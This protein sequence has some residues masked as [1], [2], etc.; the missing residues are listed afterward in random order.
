MRT[1]NFRVYAMAVVLAMAFALMTGLLLA[2]T[3][4]VQAQEPDERPGRRGIYGTVVTI[5]QENGT[6]VIS[7]R[8]GSEVNVDIS[9]TG[10]ELSVD[11]RVALLVQRGE[12]GTTLDVIRGLVRPDRPRF[13]HLTGAVVTK[14]DG[15]L[16]I[17]DATGREHVVELSE[18]VTIQAN[19][20][21]LA[22]VIASRGTDRDDDGRPLVAHASVSA[23]AITDRVR[24]HVEVI[25]GRAQ[26]GEFHGASA[27]T[28]IQFLTGLLDTMSIRIKTVYTNVLARVGSLRAKDAV[29]S[30]MDRA[31]QRL[32]HAKTRIAQRVV[33]SQDGHPDQGTPGILS[34]PGGRPSGQPE[35]TPG[36]Q[37]QG[38]SQ[39][40]PVGRPDAAG[41]PEDAPGNRG[42]AGSQTG[43]APG[44][45]PDDAGQP[46]NTPRGSG[47]R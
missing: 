41:Q 34:N 30:A 8:S 42:Q 28:R 2:T 37:A 10:L 17:I 15:A 32:Q 3:T 23:Q 40:A 31:L 7:T 22:T 9:T 36:D 18:G 43:D 45:R 5:S 46:D 25:R 39:D 6:A 27:E 19:P 11:D 35:D 33:P 12:K 24:N 29:Q 4:L 14:T 21:E 13:L 1:Q 20:G 26:A 38:S 44:G 16:T 47:L